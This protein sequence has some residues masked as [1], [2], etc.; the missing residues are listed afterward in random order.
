M[1][2][3]IVAVYGFSVLTTVVYVLS[4]YHASKEHPVL[5]LAVNMAVPPSGTILSLT[6]TLSISNPDTALTL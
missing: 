4:E 3:V 2:A 5:T 1:S 6:L